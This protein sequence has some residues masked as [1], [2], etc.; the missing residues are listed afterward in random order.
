MSF[1]S[2]T[3]I[4]VFQQLVSARLRSGDFIFNFMIMSYD[5]LAVP[6]GGLVLWLCICIQE[7]RRS[8]NLECWVQGSGVRMG[9]ESET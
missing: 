5:R 4:D 6:S 3:W 2:G 8:G 7:I 1:V 9:S